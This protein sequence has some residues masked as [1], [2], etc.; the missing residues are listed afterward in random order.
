MKRIFYLFVLLVS[1]SVVSLTAGAYT[2]EFDGNIYE[3][4]N[5]TAIYTFT[6][7][8]SWFDF[9]RY[10]NTYSITIHDTVWRKGT[11]YPVT[12]IS[13][14]KSGMDQEL[15][16]L[17]R[18]PN[19]VKY[20]TDKALA[21]IDPIMRIAKEVSLRENPD[22]NIKV[23]GDSAFYD[24][25]LTD[26]FSL[27]NITSIG[28]SAFE[29]CYK[30]QGISLGNALH[31]IKSRAFYNT[32]IDSITFGKSIETIGA[33]AF[34]ECWKLTSVKFV[35]I[36]AAIEAGAFATP[37]ERDKSYY[38]HPSYNDKTIPTIKNVDISDP[39][40]WCRVKMKSNPIVQ[41]ET[42]TVNGQAVSHL[43]VV[44][45]KEGIA[46]NVFANAKNLTAI[47]VTGGGVIEGSAFISCTNVKDL[48]LEVDSIGSGAFYISSREEYFNPKVSLRR[49]Y[50]LTPTPPAVSKYAF[51][52]YSGIILYVPAGC[53]DVYR[54]H[55]IWGQFSDIEESDFE[56]LD[57]IFSFESGIGD[58]HV[59]N[60]DIYSE[61]INAPT[62]IYTLDGRYVGD[63][64]SML[65][66]GIYI[67]RRG[68]VSRK[69][70]IQ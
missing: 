29:E 6:R 31:T 47:R 15:I 10:P 58:I 40:K 16:F 37:H 13:P 59:D 36:P 49:I 19:T 61:D 50:S 56:G 14:R 64:A 32:G 26:A 52:N 62:R 7:H 25:F 4:S 35:G 22:N 21:V 30:L 48:C 8:P 65:T 24:S 39:Q 70:A 44:A 28:K 3:L 27:P 1:A 11:S 23:I 55:R 63:N 60:S 17:I 43:D 42:F 46:S 45:G 67:V 53:K 54:R 34:A 51:Y 57:D 12:T 20:I 18:I 38:A 69:I 9:P 68:H 41:S 33:N 66:P 5:D 2:Q